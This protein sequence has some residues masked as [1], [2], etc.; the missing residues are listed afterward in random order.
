MSNKNSN[1]S[2]DRNENLL[3]NFK[4]ITL[5][6]IE[7]YCPK[8]IVKKILNQKNCNKYKFPPINKSNSHNS[9]RVTY[10]GKTEETSNL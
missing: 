7:L 2:D 1:S 8:K 6:K 4:F 3:K 5:D 9:K 10:N